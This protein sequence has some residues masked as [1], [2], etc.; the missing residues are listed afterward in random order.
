MGYYW[1]TMDKD[2]LD[3]VWRCTACQFHAS[4]IHHPPEVLHPTIW[5]LIFDTWGLDVV[6]GQLQ[7]S[8]CRPLYILA[9]TDY[10]SKWAEAVSLKEVKKDNVEIFIWVNIIYVFGISEN[11]KLFDKKLMNK[12]CYLFVFNKRK[13]SIYHVASNGLAEAFNKTLCNLQK[14]FVFKTNVLVMKKGRSFVGI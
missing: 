8:I 12:K 9:V 13:S 14:K 3:C 2:F 7:K 11:E 6:V 5:S 4:F 1:P 10:F